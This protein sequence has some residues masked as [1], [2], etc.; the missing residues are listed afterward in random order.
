MADWLD[1]LEAGYR[2]QKTRQ[3]LSSELQLHRAQVLKNK[4]R[5]LLDQFTAIVKHDVERY[6]EK[7]K[8]EPER[9]ADFN[10]KPSG[11]FSLHKMHYPAAS[12]ECM[13]DVSSSVIRADS[14]FRPNSDSPTQQATN[15]IRLGVDSN[16]NITMEYG[17]RPIAT[18]EELS[19]TLIAP[20]LFA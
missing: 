11:G 20:V 9:R 6:S 7:F 18:L 3:E 4:A 14:T 10:A 19:R 8:N 5:G 1:D 13:L 15:V 16:D 12:I 2:R 17:G